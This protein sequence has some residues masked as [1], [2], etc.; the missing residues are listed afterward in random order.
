MIDAYGY[1]LNVGIVLCNDEGRVFWGR[2]L[3]TSS[4]Q[5]P[6]GGIR[7]H[8]KPEMALYRELYEEVGL[9]RADV[10]FMGKTRHWL[11]Y[12]LPERYIRRYSYPLCIG[13]KQLWYMLRLTTQESR[14][15]L[16]RTS[17]PEFDSWCWVDYWYPVHDVVYFKRR[18]YRQALTELGRCLLERKTSASL[19]NPRDRPAK[20]S[21]IIIAR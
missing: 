7:P 6:Q 15:S 1:R 12:D 17:R 21:S 13:Q 14:I 5:F 19:D 20:S 16:N 4:W 2:R 8:E 11:R 18:V 9:K 10:Q 3:G